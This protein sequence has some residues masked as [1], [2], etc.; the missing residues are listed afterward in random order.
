MISSAV[1]VKCNST[2]VEVGVRAPVRVDCPNYQGRLLNKLGELLSS[3]YLT[4]AASALNKALQVN[5]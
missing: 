1:G 4:A 5:G 2:V 3:M